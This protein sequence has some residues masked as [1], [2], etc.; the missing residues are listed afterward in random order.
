MYLCNADVTVSC[1]IEIQPRHVYWS[2]SGNLVCLATDE[3]Y[4]VLKYNSA[5]VSRARESS[6]N[7]TEDGIEDAFEVCSPSNTTV[8]TLYRANANSGRAVA[9]ANEDATFLKI[10]S[11]ILRILFS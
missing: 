5:V 7:V 9:I 10:G 4:Y 8:K 1:S 3:A 2:E 11:H 6:S